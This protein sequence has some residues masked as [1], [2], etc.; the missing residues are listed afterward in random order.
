MLRNQYFA[1][2][3]E[4]KQHKMCVLCGVSI[5]EISA[6]TWMGSLIPP[7]PFSSAIVHRHLS[8]AFLFRHSNLCCERN[9]WPG[10]KKNPLCTQMHVYQHGYSVSTD[11]RIQTSSLPR[12][13][14]V[15][16][17]GMTYFIYWAITQ[18]QWNS[19]TCLRGTLYAS[20]FHLRTQ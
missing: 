13:Q 20:K 17:I 11:T 15:K 4:Q 3:W 16:L 7:T 8:K 19:C 2:S 9:I 1:S 18:H 14:T 10:N 6:Q 12:R 5:T